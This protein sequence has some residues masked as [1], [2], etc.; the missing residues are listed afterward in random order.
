MDELERDHL[1]TQLQMA[2]RAF[3]SYSSVGNEEDGYMVVDV[4][5]LNETEIRNLGEIAGRIE[6]LARKLSPGEDY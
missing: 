1:T 6:Y 3:D 2:I 5:N 4:E